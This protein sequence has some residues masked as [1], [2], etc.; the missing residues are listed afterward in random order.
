MYQEFCVLDIEQKLNEKQIIIYTNKELSKTKFDT[1]AVI[2]VFERA[3][4]SSPIFTSYIDDTFKNIVIEFKDWPV[5]NTEYIIS[6]KNLYT[7][8]DEPLNESLKKKITFKSTIS[9]LITIKSPIMFEQIKENNLT[10]SIE[11]NDENN[12][13]TNHY[14]LEIAPTTA[15]N[16]VI[17]KTT[18]DKKEFNL[19]LPRE[20]QYFLRIR[21][22]STDDSEYGKWSKVVSFRY[23]DKIYTKDEDDPNYQDID[24]KLDDVPENVDEEGNIDIDLEPFEIIGSLPQNKTP[25]KIVI[26]FSKKLDENVIPKIKLLREEVE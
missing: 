25:K 12:N 5:P 8:V 11:E 26:H 2:E 1:E 17:A 15:F 6:V 19:V 10:I 22:Q 18:F 9:S 4:K 20:D 21:A 7:I 16:E 24:V 14:Y 13:F 23:G 3:T